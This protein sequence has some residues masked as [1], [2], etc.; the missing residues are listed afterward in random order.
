MTGAP[1]ALFGLHD[2]GRL[3]PGMRADIVLFDPST[4]GAGPATAVRDLPGGA[5]RMTAAPTGITNVWVNGVLTAR[6]GDATGA[7][8]GSVLRSGRDTATVLARS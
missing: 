1:A 2:R 6:D 7:T 4:I 3:A 8:P 5:V